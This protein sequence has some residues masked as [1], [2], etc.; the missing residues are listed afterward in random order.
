M[1]KTKKS[2]P[3]RNITAVQRYFWQNYLAHSIE[4]GLYMG[5]LSFLAA[6]TVMPAMVK[7]LG[8]PSWLI[9]LMPMMMMFGIGWPSL[10][11]AHWVERLPR[12]KPFILATGFLQRLPYLI[13]ALS[14]FLFI[15]RH[16]VIVLML[17]ALAPLLSGLLTGL[18]FAAWMDLIARII[19]EERR[20]SAWAIRWIITAVIGIFAGSII[21]SVL[22]RSP[23][24][25]GYSILH[26]IA[27][28]FC[29]LSYILQAMFHEIPSPYQA[30]LGRGLAENLRSLPGLLRADRRFLNFISMRMLT[31]GIYIMTP[32]LAIHALTILGKDEDYLGFFVIAKMVGSILG[33]L[34]AGYLGDHLGSRIPLVLARVILVA[35][36]MVAA[37]NRFEWGFLAIFFFF[38]F[39]FYMNQVGTNT[40]SLE[41]CPTDRIPTYISLLTTLTSPS[42]LG[43]A[44][45]STVVRELT[46]QF[47]PAAFISAITVMLS[48]LFLSR[49]EEPRKKTGVTN[50]G[51]LVPS[52][53]C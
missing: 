52:N 8:G 20:A 4:G 26:L 36:S 1:L 34:I 40:L 39:A 2:V 24:P 46:G 9:S 31:M 11:T 10:L 21:K 17:V 22:A 14:L 18:N 47:M 7:D 19:P 45:I 41:I 5:G 16:P 35:V 38:G 50:G 33:N 27:F 49:I 28:G 3:N 44:V 53:D 6:E 15:D 29:M 25:P 42:M 51:N 32:F 48:L 37:V 23:G 12:V 43:A 30:D 13:A